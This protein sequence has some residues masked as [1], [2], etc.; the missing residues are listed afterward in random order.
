MKIQHT[1]DSAVVVGASATN[2]GLNLKDPSI[3]VQMLL[4]LYSDPISSTIR[5]LVS[6]AWDANKESNSTEP[7][8]V[9]LLDG[10]FFVRDFGT[11]ISPEF[12]NDGYCIIGYSTK[13]DSDEFIGGYGFGRVSPL[14]Y[15]TQYW[16]NTIY[17][18]VSYQYLIFLDESTIKQVLLHQEPCLDPSGT[19]VSLQIKNNH[20]IGQWKRSIHNQCAYFHN[21]VISIEDTREQVIVQDGLYK[22]TK[23]SN[24]NITTGLVLGSV[25][26]PLKGGNDE[27]NSELNLVVHF[28][29]DEGI[30]PNPSRE[31]YVLNN[32]TKKK[33]DSRLNIIY[34][35]I[36]DTMSKEASIVR[37]M[38]DLDKLFAYHSKHPEVDWNI[39]KRLLYETLSEALGEDCIDTE[40]SEYIMNW[41]LFT[42]VKNSV[43]GLH[44][45]M[46]CERWTK[47]KYE[48]ANINNIRYAAKVSHK[49]KVGVNFHSIPDIAD[50]DQKCDH[51]VS[52]LIQSYI[53]KYYEPFDEDAYNKWCTENKTKRSLP[54]GDIKYYRSSM[55]SLT[56][57]LDKDV[58][59]LEDRKTYHYIFKASPETAKKYWTFI[60]NNFSKMIMTKNY[61]YDLDKLEKDPILKRM[62]S[63][64]FR[65]KIMND[66]TFL[67][68]W[69]I[70]NYLDDI[71]PQ[72]SQV[73]KD[74]NL[75]FTEYTPEDEALYN[76][77]C[78]LNCFDKDE[79][80]LRFVDSRCK[81]LKFLNLI[82]G[83][84][85]RYFS[86]EEV[87]LIKRQ[88]ILSRHYDKNP[89]ELPV[90]Q[91]ESEHELEIN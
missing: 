36:F 25:L 35:E 41:N 29:L 20:E 73:I 22:H 5:E 17:N 57:T 60:T 21:T 72:L 42:H 33:I 56:C 28:D 51:I 80:S 24:F 52:T 30:V 54:K 79:A 9:G 69:R 4:N 3:F 11:G 14:S 82:G 90:E 34:K 19:M 65:N 78:T 45:S 23:T 49:R 68:N 13:R 40:H 16:V 55:I 15:S 70:V 43:A 71:D 64:A 88:Y 83:V 61:G 18:G 47:K 74:L 1:K 53:E 62:V 48:W 63:K 12:M 2:F 6:N 85:G 76:L 86:D 84:S 89:V 66:Y 67:R 91:V 8:V 87:A 58:I 10:K 75:Q 38:D 26:Y 81:H 32:E 7:V 50:Y 77:G 27:L 44:G 39:K 59:N 37:D 31:A 46:Y